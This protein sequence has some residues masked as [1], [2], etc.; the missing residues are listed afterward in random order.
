MHNSLEYPI[1]V[2]ILY[3]GGD[4]GDEQDTLTAVRSISEALE[5]R[6]HMVRLMEVTAK[7][8]RNAT[9]I[10]GDVVFNLVEDFDWS[11][12]MKVAKRLEQMGRAQVGH[13]IKCLKFVVKKAKVKRKMQ[14]GGIS[15]PPFRIFNRRSNVSAVRRIDFPVIV[16]PSG[17][18][19]GIGISQDS[20]V[21]DKKELEERVKYVFKNFPG[22][23][24]AEEFVEGKELHV[25]MLGNGDHVVA[26]PIC[27][28]VFGGEFADNWPVYT[29][30]AK[31]EKESWEYWSARV[32][33]PAVISDKLSKKVEKLAIKTFKEFGCRDVARVDI[34]VDD[35]E[36][37]YV[38]DLNISPSLNGGDEEDASIKSAEAL[39]W[40]YEE[41]IEKIVAIT[42]K[43][44]YGA[45]PDRIRERHFLLSAPIL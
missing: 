25:T 37:P 8:W 2:A 32:H 20:V 15:T 17:Q 43:R 26:L 9:R 23:V 34:R 31:W 40:S 42:Y 45:L 14:R 22:E 39:G 27:E 3:S 1:S 10:P 33:A 30:E 35:K 24:I 38:V 36:R 4:A 13:D 19:A 6:G 21:I 12:Y 5:K 16:K 44:I 11:L 28:I 7:N 18:H 29:Y 41:F